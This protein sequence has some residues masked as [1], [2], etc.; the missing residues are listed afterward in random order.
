MAS[1][2]GARALLLR[3]LFELMRHGV[4]I[5]LGGGVAVDS[6]LGLPITSLDVDGRLV[7]MGC[8]QV[9]CLQV[10]CSQVGLLRK[11]CPHCALQIADAVAYFRAEWIRYGHAIGDQLDDWFPEPILAY[12][13][14]NDPELRKSAR[15][16][17]YVGNAWVGT[18]TN[19]YMNKL[20]LLVKCAGR[21]HKLV[22]VSYGAEC[23]GPAST[24]FM[25]ALGVWCDD[26][27]Y[28][29]EKFSQS[30]RAKSRVL[31]R[32]LGDWFNVEPTTSGERYRAH[33]ESDINSRLAKWNRA[34]RRL[35]LIRGKVAA[36]T[37][38]DVQLLQLVADL[39]HYLD[40]ADRSSA[41]R[42][43]LESVRAAE[44]AERAARV[45]ASTDR[46]PTARI[47]RGVPFVPAPR[48]L[49]LVVH[50]DLAVSR[51]LEEVERAARMWAEDPLTRIAAQATRRQ[52]ARAAEEEER[53][54]RTMAPAVPTWLRRAVVAAEERE[55]CR[56]VSEAASAAVPTPAELATSRAESR[57]AEEEERA[58][59]RAREHEME[60]AHGQ[61]DPR[62][63]LQSITP[64]EL[65]RGLGSLSY[66]TF[67][68][69]TGELINKLLAARLPVEA[70]IMD[71]L[72]REPAAAP[73]RDD[74]AIWELLMPHE[75]ALRALLSSACFDYYWTVRCSIPLRC[76][77]TPEEIGRLGPIAV[78][79]EIIEQW[80]W[81][82]AHSNLSRLRTAVEDAA[83][84]AA[85][86]QHSDNMTANLFRRLADSR[87]IT[88]ELELLRSLN[89]Q[90][91][92]IAPGFDNP[93]VAAV[94]NWLAQEPWA[95]V[96]RCT[97]AHIHREKRNIAAALESALKTVSALH[98]TCAARTMANPAAE[99][100]RQC[101]KEFT[102]TVKEAMRATSRPRKLIRSRPDWFQR[103]LNVVEISPSGTAEEVS[104][105]L[106]HGLQC[107]EP[108]S[109]AW[110]EYCQE[111]IAAEQFSE[112]L[113]ADRSEGLRGW[114][115]TLRVAHAVDW[116]IMYIEGIL[117]H[118]SKINTLAEF[119]G[120]VVE[121][122]RAPAAP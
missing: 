18:I 104:R 32:L 43:T 44:E 89:T 74:K 16:G 92:R 9:G 42:A 59:R 8:S 52:L 29:E 35:E 85:E 47:A 30:L 70:A 102:G 20:I 103:K 88:E 31:Q 45:A 33:L 27:K 19:D 50:D 49:N 91:D 93:T 81:V 63:L 22:E 40:R 10:S 39:A 36:A 77:M 86:E 12:D 23:A 1:E 95:H 106:A 119:M 110:S 4:I 98:V 111:L 67:R 94:R 21:A 96:A 114:H 58:R 55:R 113:M 54:C 118:V 82:A 13:F 117:L 11:G 64:R 56:R 100:W 15:S 34:R 90:I 2:L 69:V 116:S 73:W 26:W 41:A 46:A 97:L 6:M 17:E 71:T 62:T 99:V 115:C 87:A 75:Q 48:L 84:A 76:N 78:L 101:Y 28:M 65:A 105:A 66:S 3:P 37:E 112:R 107:Q 120:W 122:C 24:R 72:R 14:D 109:L 7:V 57:A 121:Q 61:W 53:R 51:A 79:N 5:S 83:A 68:R 80:L 60:G 108:S 25:P 38:C